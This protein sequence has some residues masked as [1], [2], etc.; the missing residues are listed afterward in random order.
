M[1]SPNDVGVNIIDDGAD[2]ED[3]SEQQDE[4]GRPLNRQTNNIGDYNNPRDELEDG[5]DDNA[6]AYGD[7]IINQEDSSNFNV[8]DQHDNEGM[9]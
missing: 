7:E 3:E 2:F 5:E 4:E 6:A 1:V 9:E 8:G